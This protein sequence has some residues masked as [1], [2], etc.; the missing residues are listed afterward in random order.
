M[1]TPL[2]HASGCRKEIIPHLSRVCYWWGGVL[3]LPLTYP[4]DG[5]FSPLGPSL[6][7]WV[8]V[9]RHSSRFIVDSVR[10]WR[11]SP[12]KRQWKWLRSIWPTHSEFMLPCNSILKLHCI[13]AVKSD[14][15]TCVNITLTWESVITHL[16]KLHR[17]EVDGFDWGRESIKLLKYVCIRLDLIMS[18]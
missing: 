7:G 16:P 1:N 4:N 17:I 8:C 12:W 6:C 15:I 2:V 13:R 5:W 9:F 18:C 10:E 14:R 3:R 11:S